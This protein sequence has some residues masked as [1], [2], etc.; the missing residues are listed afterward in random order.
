MIQ[1]VIVEKRSEYMMQCLICGEAVQEPD[2]YK[3]NVVCPKCRRAIRC[4]REFIEHINADRPSS[5][6]VR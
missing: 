3:N 1:N 5:N 4:V 2:F 6:F